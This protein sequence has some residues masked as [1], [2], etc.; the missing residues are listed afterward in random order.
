M[1]KK[2][3]IKFTKTTLEM[4]FDWGTN[5]NEMLF[6]MGEKKKISKLPKLVVI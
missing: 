6:V 1:Q 5:C 4:E 3:K 2:N